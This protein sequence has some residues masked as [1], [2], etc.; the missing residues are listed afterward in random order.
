VLENLTLNCLHIQASYTL[1][2]LQQHRV[3]SVNIANRYGLEVPGIESRC[4]RGLPDPSK[5]AMG[6]DPA[7]CT[8]G[9]E[10][11]PGVK[12]RGLVLEHPLPYSGEVK[13]RVE[14]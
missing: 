14:L 2:L 12:R 3:S 4:G 1:K 6:A 8:I 9:T 7:S 10:T 5:T 11:L 13:E